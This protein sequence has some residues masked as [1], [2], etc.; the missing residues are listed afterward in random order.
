[1]ADDVQKWASIL[2][3]AGAVGLVG[4]LSLDAVPSRPAVHKE[5]D[6]GAPL[7]AGAESPAIL[8]DASAP[9]VTDIDGGLSLANFTLD[10]GVTTI[11]SGAPRS[12]K[13]GIV[14]V[15]YAGAEGA[16][17]NARSKQAALTIAER[18]LGDARADFHK[19]TASGDPGSA[20]DI[21][22]IPRGVLDPRTEVAVF[23]LSSG[24]VSEVLDTPKGYWIV[25]RIE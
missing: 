22:R 3:A 17:P 2:V 8:A 18:L 4:Y 11:P 20:D 25:K 23:G 14:L 5:P 15:A 16:P 21:G 13:I 19:A 1:M 9:T 10:A 7:D 24:D 12:V 6:A